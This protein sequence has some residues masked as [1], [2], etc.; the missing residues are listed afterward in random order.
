MNI[1]L[2]P[3]G[4]KKEL[5]NDYI[6]EV[7][8]PNANT[9]AYRPLESNA[10]DIVWGYNWTNV[11]W[12]SYDTLASWKK[13]AKATTT[14]ANIAISWAILD[15]IWSNDFTISCWVYL[16]WVNT[17]WYNITSLFLVIKNSSPYPW[18]QIFLSNNSNWWSWIYFAP[19]WVSWVSSNTSY[20]NVINR[21]INIVYTRSSWVCKWYINA[22]QE[23][24]QNSNISY[25]W[26]TWWFLFARW[27]SNQQLLTWSMGSEYIL[28][29]KWWTAQEILN[30]Y[31]KTKSN[32]WL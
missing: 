19:Q 30:Y 5:K 13:V 17:M 8:T 16:T 3:S 22:V 12:I 27:D 29:L 18:P 23:T 4:V 21:W 24:T 25:S 20:D 7:W 9:I 28:E 31:N 6:G 26:W 11:S 15:R 14:T 10:N 1:Y 32:Y 2:H